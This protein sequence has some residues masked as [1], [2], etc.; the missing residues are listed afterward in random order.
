MEAELATLASLIDRI[1]ERQ[2]AS[3]SGK[4]FTQGSDMFAN[5]DNAILL[6]GANQYIRGGKVRLAASGTGAYWLSKKAFFVNYRAGSPPGVGPA[7]GKPFPVSGI[8]IQQMLVV[9]WDLIETKRPDG[10]PSG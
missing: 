1:T 8:F 5:R 7:S 2:P 6:Q 10:W 9:Y 4:G 3:G